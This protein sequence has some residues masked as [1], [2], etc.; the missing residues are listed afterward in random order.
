MG[1]VIRLL[2]FVGVM[3]LSWSAYPSASSETSALQ[4]Q[5][6]AIKKGFIPSRKEAIDTIVL[7]SS[8]NKRDA[9][10]YSVAKLIKIYED[11]NVSP[12]YLIDREGKIY[13]LFPDSYTAYHAGVSR[14]PDGRTGVNRF[15]LGIEIMN[16]GKDD[17]TEAQYQSVRGLVQVLKQRHAIKHVVG[18]GQIAPERRSDPWNF[19]WKCLDN[20]PAEIT[21]KLVC[22]SP[23]TSSF[24]LEIS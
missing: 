17:Y 3:L 23:Q 2:L 24:L 21:L 22:G 12:H 1:I 13:Q 14:M 7:H 15:S 16:N 18:H 10:S 5:P 19:N 11:Y 6:L 8:Y 9:D 20:N 4:L